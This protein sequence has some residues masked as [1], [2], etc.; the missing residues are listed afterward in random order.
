MCLSTGSASVQ[1]H[2]QLVNLPAVL[3]WDMRG[4]IPLESGTTL[5][6]LLAGLTPWQQLSCCL[7]LA[8][9]QGPASSVG[10]VTFTWFEAVWTA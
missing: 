1:F 3:S 5:P 9:V 4:L 10:G 7:T 8:E 6:H 2:L